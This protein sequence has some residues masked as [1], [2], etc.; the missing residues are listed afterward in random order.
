MNIILT[1]NSKKWLALLLVLTGVL[2]LYLSRA[3][4]Y[5]IWFDEATE[6]FYSKYM[7]G[8]VP[9]AESTQNMYERICNTYQPPLYNCL[10]YVWLSCFDTEFGFRL[11]G[12]I[13]TLVGGIG[14][15]L[16]LNSMTDYKWASCGSL[17][18]LLSTSVS[19]YALECAEYNLM[20]CLLC[21]CLCFY[22]LSV[23]DTQIKYIAA[24]FAFVCLSVYSQYGAAFVVIPLYVSLMLH[25]FPKREIRKELLICTFTAVVSAVVLVLFFFIPQITK[26][27]TVSVSH[28]PNFIFNNILVDVLYG[29][30]CQTQY[31]FANGQCIFVLL[32]LTAS[33]IVCRKVKMLRS[34]CCVGIVCWFLYYI[35]AAFSFYGYNFYVPLTGT[36]NLG[37][38]YGLFLSPLLLFIACCGLYALLEKVSAKKPVLYFLYFVSVCLFVNFIIIGVKYVKD[39][40][41][42]DNSLAVV[43]IDLHQDD[44]LLMLHSVDKRMKTQNDFRSLEKKWI[45]ERAYTSRTLIHV[46][47]SST[48]LYY[49]MHDENYAESWRNNIMIADY[50]IFFGNYN[51]MK[52][53]LQKIG[54]INI[55]SV[56]FISPVL[57]NRCE[58]GNTY[59]F[60]N[61]FINV[62]ADNGY[63]VNKLYEDQSALVHAVK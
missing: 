1:E 27:G 37:N 28:A 57:P 4:Y 55:N 3:T 31:C 12:I 60:Y 63:N 52:D 43:N 2:L 34:I 59:D 33:L 11:A 29:F 7:F 13:T 40:F 25:L 23:I 8:P 47:S 39:G 35:A 26:Q 53:A 38:R 62:M 58:D 44:K 42:E 6:Y 24:F 32:S 50:W 56:Y 16:A 20:L 49:M 10:M 17:M 5:S 9:M 14:F 51:N 36:Q 46:W 18:Y 61:S 54:I 15:F 48:F 41:L 22:V 30:V 19:Y 45:S 21:W